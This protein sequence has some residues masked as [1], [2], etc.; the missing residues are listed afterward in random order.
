MTTALS[1]PLQSGSAVA[2]WKYVSRVCDRHGGVQTYSTPYMSGRNLFTYLTCVVGQYIIGPIRYR[3]RVRVSG[4]GC[5]A[6][7]ISTI[8]LSRLIYHNVVQITLIC[9]SRTQ[10]CLTDPNLIGLC[11]RRMLNKLL[12]SRASPY[13]RLSHVGS[14]G[15]VILR[16]VF[17]GQVAEV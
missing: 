10:S 2:G 15:R 13:K 9:P 7:A 12:R 16:C 1:G 14:T 8:V 3:R 5:R 17:D 11:V 6:W 4:N